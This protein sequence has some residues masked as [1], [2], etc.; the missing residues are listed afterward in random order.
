[1]DQKPTRISGENNETKEKDEKTRGCRKRRRIDSTLLNPQ[2]NPLAN[3]HVVPSEG[4]VFEFAQQ[5]V[6]D[7]VLYY[8]Q[9]NQCQFCQEPIETIPFTLW[10]CGTCFLCEGCVCKIYDK[11]RYKWSSRHRR[12]KI[13][14]VGNLEQIYPNHFTTPSQTFTDDIKCYI[15]RDGGGRTCRT[16]SPVTCNVTRY[17]LGKN[18]LKATSRPVPT[19]STEI[20]MQ[21]ILQFKRVRNSI[22]PSKGTYTCPHCKIVTFRY[23]QLKEY[24]RHQTVCL[25][26]RVQCPFTD[27]DN[28]FLSRMLRETSIGQE[29]LDHLLEVS[30]SDISSRIEDHFTMECSHKILCNIRTCDQHPS[31]EKNVVSRVVKLCDIHEHCLKILASHD[32]VNVTDLT[33][34]KLPTWNEHEMREKFPRDVE[35]CQNAQEDEFTV[36]LLLD[37][38]S[39]TSGEDDDEQSEAI[40]NVTRVFVE[41]MRNHS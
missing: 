12:P 13:D 38:A 41:S 2:L 15:C 22:E 16:T 19:S 9:H 30:P 21:D 33:K 37:E 26:R 25:F 8:E 17:L 28:L 6:M 4:V 35:M 40:Q 27:C 10:T 5:F 34:K 3:N 23:S 24:M 36:A 31:D 29:T 7:H 14:M 20:T 1:M 11:Y 39:G 32:I 18:F